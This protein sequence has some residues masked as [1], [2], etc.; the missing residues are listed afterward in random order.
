M[1][2]H[3]EPRTA[4]EEVVRHTYPWQYDHDV[5]ST[6]K[7]ID[8]A[9]AST[10]NTLTYDSVAIHRGTDMVFE[11]NIGSNELRAAEAPKP[12]PHYE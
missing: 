8:T 5:I 7:S 9:E 10:G 12:N 3:S 6:G 2:N 1:F 4:K 11:N